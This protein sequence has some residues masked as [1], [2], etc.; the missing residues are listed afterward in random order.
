ML[1]TTLTTT[2]SFDSLRLLF[3]GA[4]PSWDLFIILFFLVLSLIYGIALGRDRIIV[5]MV[6]IYMALAVVKY[7]PFLSEFNANLVLKD[8]FALKVSLFLGLFILLFFFISHSALIRTLGSGAQQGRFWHVVLFSIL[9]AGLFIS[10]TLSF[11]PGDM[12]PWISPTMSELFVSDT[13][14]AVWILLPIFAMVFVGKSSGD[15]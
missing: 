1:A 14:K 6:S 13:A 8:V 12:S 9:H 15:D 2:L 10:V 5:I 7:V 11:F 4:Q 3:N